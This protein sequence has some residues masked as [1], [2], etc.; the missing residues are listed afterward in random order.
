MN[1]TE[2]AYHEAGYCLERSTTTERRLQLGKELRAMLS[3]ETPEDQHYARQLI[4]KG[5][6]EAKG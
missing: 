3:S 4:E 5:R 6:Q 2:H 1:H